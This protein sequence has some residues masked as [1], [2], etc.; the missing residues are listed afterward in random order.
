LRESEAAAAH[1][2]P[3]DG[4]VD[5]RKRRLSARCAGESQ[6][7]SR[8]WRLLPHRSVDRRTTPAGEVV[9]GC[10]PASD[11]ALVCR[12]I[13]I[14]RDVIIDYRKGVIEFDEVKP[15]PQQLQP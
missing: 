9:P 5:Y 4:R 14:N 1:D 7:S 11:V 6:H 3:A 8:R 10:L 15:R 12:W 2:R 13:E